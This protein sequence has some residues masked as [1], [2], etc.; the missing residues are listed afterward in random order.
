M[1]LKKREINPKKCEIMKNK[2]HNQ[3][4]NKNDDRKKIKGKVGFH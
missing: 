4:K 3:I 1:N 2:N